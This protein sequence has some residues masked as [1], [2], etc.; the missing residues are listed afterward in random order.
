MKLKL[1]KKRLVHHITNDVAQIIIE[2]LK[3]R[4]LGI[5]MYTCVTCLR[6]FKY[7]MW[8]IDLTFNRNRYMLYYCSDVCHEPHKSAAKIQKSL[9]LY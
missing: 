7:P 5:S 1:A 4:R 2:Y 6:K 8:T 9:N 3:P